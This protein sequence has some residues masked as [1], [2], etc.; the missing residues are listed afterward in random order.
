MAHMNMAHMRDTKWLTLEVCREFQRGTCSRSDQEC[1]FAHP[2]KSCQVE[3]G[4]VIACFD[5]LKGRCSRENCKYLHPPGHLKTQLEINGRN[6]LIQQKNM[7]MLAQQMQLANAMMPGTQLQPMVSLYDLVQDS[8]RFSLHQPMF[9][10]APGLA[11][12]ASAAAAAFNP[13]LGPVSPGLMQAEIMP[14]PQVLMAGHPNH[15]QVPNA[16]AAA[17]QKLM[18]TDR[19]EV[20]REYQRGNCS[21]GENDCRFSH[22]SDSTMIDTNDNTVTVCMDYIKGRCSR[23]KCKYFHPPAHLQAKIKAAQHQVNQAT[24]AAAMGIPHSVMP[25]M[26]KRAALEKPNGASAMFNTGML[27]YQHAL[28]N[29]QFQQQ[30]AFLPSVPMMHGGTQASA[31]TTSATSVPFATSSANQDSSLSKLTTNEYMQL[32]PIISADHLSSHKYL[33]QM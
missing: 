1:K 23:E 32:I 20:C 31:A 27:Q 10:M 2:A 29:M 12:N 30:A 28:A 24:A 11:T 18:R 4:R 13:Y 16:A 3:N 9:S 15:G 21:R 14:S 7:A 22:P 19:L 26:P 25:P 5:S 8:N 33:T 17:A 6:N